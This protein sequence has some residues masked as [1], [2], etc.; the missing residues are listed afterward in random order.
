MAHFST[1]GVD[2]LSGQGV[3]PGWLPWCCHLALKALAASC[4]VGT[5]VANDLLSVRA[6]V[7]VTQCSLRLATPVGRPRGGDP[8]SPTACGAGPVIQRAT[9]TSTQTE[10]CHRISQALTLLCAPL[11]RV[12]PP[13]RGSATAP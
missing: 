13:S 2:H 1:P 10:A 8:I 5:L 12:S 7:P 9:S 4:G 3:L 6:P 11:P